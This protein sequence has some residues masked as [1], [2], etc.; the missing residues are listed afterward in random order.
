[1]FQVIEERRDAYRKL[2]VRG[3]RLIGAMLVGNTTATGRLVQLFDREDPMPDDPLEVLCQLRSSVNSGPRIVCNC[4]KVSDDVLLDAIMN[5]AD[6]IA[7]VGEATK[8]GTGCGSCKGELA[9]LIS[10][11]EKKRPALPMAA[12][13]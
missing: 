3:G 9:Q 8:A 6:S 13:N 2:V 4:H 10:T 12:A 7:A 5:G 1:V 11:C